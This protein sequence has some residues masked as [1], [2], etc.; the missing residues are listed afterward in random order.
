MTLASKGSLIATMPV[1]GNTDVVPSPCI[2]SLVE[3]LNVLS[4]DL[5]IK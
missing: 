5:E 2:V 1:N 4:P 3:R